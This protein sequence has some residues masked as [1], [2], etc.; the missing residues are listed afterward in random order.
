[1]L[2]R[3]NIF[4]IIKDHFKTLRSLNQNSRGIYWQ[5]FILFILIPLVLSV[6]ATYNDYS[7]Q[8]QVTNLIAATSIIGGFL[9]NLLAIIYG[10]IDKIKTDADTEQNYIKKVFV[11]EIHINISFGIVLSIILVLTLILYS[12][13]FK[14]NTILNALNRGLL[15]LNYFLITE[16]TLT[17]LMVVNRV[18]ILLKKDSGD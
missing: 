16:F 11:K 5:D 4:Q 3:I 12:I 18:Y 15:G 1:M 9:F 10:Q 7:L 8:N 14:G 13:D 17:I 2:S 6:V